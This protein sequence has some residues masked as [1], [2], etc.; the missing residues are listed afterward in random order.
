MERWFPF[1]RWRRQLTPAAVR[2]DLIAGLTGAVIV[3]PQG[4]AYAF[5]AGLPPAYG[6]YAAIVPAVIAALFGSSWHSVTG[7]TAANSIVVLATVSVIALPGSS[8]YIDAVLTLTLLV[9]A[10]QLALGLMRLGGVVNFVSDTV[11]IGFTAGAAV[12]IAVSQLEQLLGLELPGDLSFFAT[13]GAALERIGES[14]PYAVVVGLSAFGVGLLA[15]YLDRR[16]PALLVGLLASSLLVALMGAE[17]YGI[18]MVGPL[19]QGL[20]SFRPPALSLDEAGALA[21]G[22]LALAML[23]LLQ[24]TSAA[25]AVAMRSKQKI[26]SNQEFIGQGLANLIGSLFS[27]YASSGSF[28]RSG[29]NYDA[30]ARTPLAAIVAAAG[31]LG[32][33]LLAPGATRYLPMPAIAGIVLLIAWNLIDFDRIRRIVRISRSEGVILLVTFSATLLLELEFAIYAGVLLSLILFLLRA[34]HPRLVPLAPVPN[35]PGVPFRNA[36]KR[37]LPECPQLKIVRVDGA[38]FFGAVDHVQTYLHRLSDQGYR[39]VLLVGS[40]VDHLDVAGAEMLAQEAQRFRALG[41]GLYFSNFKDPEIDI[42]RHPAFREAIGEASIFTSIQQAVPAV[43]ERLRDGGCDRC[44]L[45]LLL[46]HAPGT[47]A[48]ASEGDVRLTGACRR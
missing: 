47:A 22:A 7:P 2:A 19:P 38:L 31:V 45:G 11:V 15:Q 13:V 4:I 30:G 28:T 29:A 14:N 5:I 18:S 12:L 16:W 27:S 37:E 8:S 39:N 24:A 35:R 1:L 34:S 46:G 32:V 26:D 3:L 33:L 36:A 48:T 25:R 40:G 42:L 17:G 20:P 44:P 21:T 9:G 6:L 41:G 10:L 43:F 23:G